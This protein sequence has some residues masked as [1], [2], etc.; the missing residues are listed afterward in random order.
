[1]P[2]VLRDIVSRITLV[3]RR[4][5]KVLPG[6]LSA[7]S[8]TITD[9]NAARATGFYS[10]DNALHQP[11][12]TSIGKGFVISNG[13]NIRQE[14]YRSYNDSGVVD[15][16]RWVRVSTNSGDIWGAWVQQEVGDGGSSVPPLPAPVTTVGPG[17]STVTSTAFEDMPGTSTIVLTLESPAYAR[18]DMQAIIADNSGT[19]TML[20]ATV[21]GATTIGEAENGMGQSTSGFTPFGYSAGELT[22]S[23]VVLLSAGTNTFTLRRRRSAASGTHITN[24]AFMQVTPIAWVGAPGAVVDDTG[25]IALTPLNSFEGRP[26][27]DAPK[28][29]IKAG[30]VYLSGQL[31]RPTAPTALTVAFT[32]PVEA[33]PRSAFHVRG[34]DPWDV[35]FEIQTGGNVLIS[36]P[37]L[38][39][40]T[41]SFGYAVGGISFPND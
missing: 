26:S 25:W 39:N 15:M 6:R 31:V 29:R 37:T 17:S 5:G 32:L 12:S 2:G 4:L 13:A 10:S 14:F 8:E 24:Y 27:G 7:D 33:R 21:S 1:M 16:R 18:I 40:N 9:W 22:G 11:I 34:F 30:I 3:E 19:Y 36:S 28:Y 23:K 38:R 41:A 20:G 35:T